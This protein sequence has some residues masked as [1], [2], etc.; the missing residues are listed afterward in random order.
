MNKDIRCFGRERERRMDDIQDSVEASVRMNLFNN[1]EDAIFAHV[2][3]SNFVRLPLF[4][5]NKRVENF[6]PTRFQ[7]TAV[8]YT[9]STQR[10]IRYQ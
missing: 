5:F 6:D 10:A 2:C 9:Q 4:L 1:K 8:S 7:K 3:N